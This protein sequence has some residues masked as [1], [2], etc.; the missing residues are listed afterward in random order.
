MAE[1]EPPPGPGVDAARFQ[2]EAASQGPVTTQLKL[3][4]IGD[5]PSSVRAISNTRRLCEQHLAGRYELEII[6]VRQQPAAAAAAD[7]VA[8]PTL[9]KLL[10]PPV[11]RF[12]GDM[13]RS[14]GIVDAFGA[15]QP[16][17]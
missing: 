14:E 8:A 10:P 2:R 4:V 3:Y 5:A 13:S 1:S 6:D 11:R 9:I 16:V 15:A 17:S 7:L 12:V